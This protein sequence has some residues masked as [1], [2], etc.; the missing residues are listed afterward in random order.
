VTAAKDDGE[1][2]AKLREAVGKT[3]EQ[4]AADMGV[5]Q[6]TVSRWENGVASPSWWKARQLAQIFGCPLDALADDAALAVW[7]RTRSRSMGRE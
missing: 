5:E 2:I 1:R 7:L 6:P 4:L 3:Q